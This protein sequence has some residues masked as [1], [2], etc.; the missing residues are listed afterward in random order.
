MPNQPTLRRS[1]KHMLTLRLDPLHLGVDMVVTVLAASHEAISDESEA[2]T[3]LNQTTVR[4]ILKRDLATNGTERY[5]YVHE[6]YNADTGEWAQRLTW[7]IDQVRGIWPQWADEISLDP[8]EFDTN[9]TEE[10][11]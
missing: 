9:Y 6:R 4:T 7:A 1:G 2:P 5:F 10:D 11:E 3:R 8:T